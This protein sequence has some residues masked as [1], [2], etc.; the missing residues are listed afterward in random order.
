MLAQGL[1]KPDRP[2]TGFTKQ[3]DKPF[4]DEKRAELDED[5]TTP[6]GPSPHFFPDDPSRTQEPVSMPSYPQ[7]MHDA[8]RRLRD[9]DKSSPQFHQQLH[10]F[11][12]GDAYRNALSNGQSEISAWLVEYLNSV[13][14]GIILLHNMLTIDTGSHGNSGSPKPCF[15]GTLE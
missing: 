14:L 8:L 3:L 12:N 15:P 2:P 9:L 7:I 1:D 6:G 13:G 5:K 11:L 4:N 10:N